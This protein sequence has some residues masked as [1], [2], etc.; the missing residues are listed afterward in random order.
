[1][2]AMLKL[3]QLLCKSCFTKF[4]WVRIDVVGF[5]MWVF[6]H[7]WFHFLIWY[8]ANTLLTDYVEIRTIVHPL[9]SEVL[10]KFPLSTGPY[11]VAC[12]NSL[13][14]FRVLS[15]YSLK[16]LDTGGHSMHSNIL[17]QV[18]FRAHFGVIYPKSRQTSEVETK[19][20]S[21][22]TREVN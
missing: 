19:L 7:D 10:M 21:A 13:G 5:L 9:P 2:N 12:A 11:F 6:F 18:W 17:R 8:P 14:C 1:M 3:I 22:N 20:T 16:T 4:K 15:P